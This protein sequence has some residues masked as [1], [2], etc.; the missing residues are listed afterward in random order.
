LPK[1]PE[2]TENISIFKPIVDKCV[3]VVVVVVVKCLILCQIDYNRDGNTVCTASITGPTRWSSWLY[4]LQN[5]SV[6]RK[7]GFSMEQTH[8]EII[9]P[10]RHFT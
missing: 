5:E 2:A 1:C 3:V 10:I 8:I 9:D 6:L 7:L 4:K